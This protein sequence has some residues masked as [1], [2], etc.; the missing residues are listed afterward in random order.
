VP[1]ISLAPETS[2]QHL[3]SSIE[4]DVQ[5]SSLQEMRSKQKLDPVKGFSAKLGSRSS[6]PCELVS[7]GEECSQEQLQIKELTIPFEG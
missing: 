1:T 2:A 4:I 3:E 5:N 7:V 6:E